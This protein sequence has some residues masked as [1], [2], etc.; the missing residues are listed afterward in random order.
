MT[1][2]SMMIIGILSSTLLVVLPLLVHFWKKPAQVTTK[3]MVEKVV[4]EGTPAFKTAIP[5]SDIIVKKVVNGDEENGTATLVRLKPDQALNIGSDESNGIVIED[6]FVSRIHAI[7]MY[8]DGEWKI[9]DNHS[10]NGITVNGQRVLDDDVILHDDSVVELG[11]KTK[12]SFRGIA[13]AA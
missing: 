13:S 11:D 7:L 1:L 2:A 10:R 6:K 3:T 5:Y 12:L 4:E 9:R 8:R